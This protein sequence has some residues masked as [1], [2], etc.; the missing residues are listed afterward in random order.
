M[1]SFGF[2]FSCLSKEIF[3][4]F[5]ACNYLSFVDKKNP[6][7]AD[8]IE[9]AATDDAVVM[10]EEDLTQREEAIVQYELEQAQEG[11]VEL[12]ENMDNYY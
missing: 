4:L 10:S 6:E 9:E 7:H 12:L 1:K 11:Q 8:V 3:I 2:Q 5:Q